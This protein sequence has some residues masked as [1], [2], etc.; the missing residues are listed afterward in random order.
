MRVLIISDG[1]GDVDQLDRIAA[2][3]E[4]ADFVLFGGDFA[5]LGQPE[6]GQ[7]FLKRLAALHD[8]VF[9]VT[10]NCDEMDFRDTLD[11]Y[12]IGIEGSLSYYNGLILT[13]S[14][15]ASVFTGDTPNERAD[16][17]LVGDLRLVAESVPEDSPNAAGAW[18]N[19]V[20]IMHNPPKDTALDIVGKDAHVGSPLL[21]AFIETYQP[22]L[23]VSG[24]IHESAAVDA[25]GTTALVNPG[26][27]AE[28]RYAVAEIS[29]GRTQPFAVTSIELKQLSV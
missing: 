4:S 24:H 20:V 5:A 10:G 3:A 14:G 16:E 12:D 15:G 6:T 7:P 22:L 18:N 27:L 1:H 29:G 19:L 21:R 17:E 11:E 25:I 23:V 28:G 26:S 8:R 9:A 13:G 2:I